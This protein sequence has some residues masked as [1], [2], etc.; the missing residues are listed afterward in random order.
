MSGFPVVLDACVLLPMATCDLLL[1]IADAKEYRALWSQGILDEV[2]R[3][4]RTT[5]NLTP[6]R[7]RWRVGNMQRHFPDAQVLG[8]ESLIPN[9]SNDPKDR[10]VLAAAVRANADLIVTFN[11]KD[12]PQSALA[13]Y[14]ISA[15]HPDVFLCDQFDLN[16]PKVKQI[17]EDIVRDMKNP[18]M[19][20]SE[21]LEGLKRAG[22]PNFAELLESNGF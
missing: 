17:A 18:S 22:L 13:P 21:Y 19:T 20:H 14:D 12:F 5:F 4:L 15:V 9:M 10:H 11:L 8:Y 2:E 3:N 6:E 7:A 1:R 16:P